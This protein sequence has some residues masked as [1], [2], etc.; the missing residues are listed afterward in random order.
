MI[1]KKKFK[2]SSQVLEKLNTFKEKSM[3]TQLQYVIYYNW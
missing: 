3:C 1:E 2:N